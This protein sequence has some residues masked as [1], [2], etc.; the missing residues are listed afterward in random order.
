MS[1]S[2]WFPAFSVLVPGAS[3]VSFTSAQHNTPPTSTTL[4]PFTRSGATSVEGIV[5]GSAVQSEIPRPDSR[6]CLRR[7]QLGG[8][9]NKT[10]SRSVG[11]ARF[12]FAPE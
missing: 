12:P 10:F 6:A 3:G 8:L 7:M 5:R 9:V 4:C 11:P 1:L 2:S